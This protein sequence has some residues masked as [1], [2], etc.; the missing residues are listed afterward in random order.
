MIF[1]TDFKLK[2]KYDWNYT[3]QFYVLVL[4]EMTFIY[5]CV[6]LF[7]KTRNLQKIRND[8]DF[9]WNS[10]SEIKKVFN[11]FISI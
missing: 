7:V 11:H 2:I 10:D 4:C 1:L 8:F 6:A 3:I 5:S 9:F